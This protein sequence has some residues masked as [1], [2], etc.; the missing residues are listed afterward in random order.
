[1]LRK[2]GRQHGAPIYVE[3]R[4]MYL[5]LTAE[6]FNEL[7]GARYAGAPP[8][9]LA[10]DQAALWTG[11]R[12]GDI[13]VLATDHSWLLR[14]K[15]DSTNGRNGTVQAFLNKALPCHALVRRCREGRIS[16]SISSRRPQP[17]EAFWS[18]T[19]K[20]HSGHRSR[21]QLQWDPTEQRIIDATAMHTNADFSPY[22][23]WVVTWSRYTTTIGRGEI[24][25]QDAKVTALRGRGR[26]VQRK[27]FRL[28]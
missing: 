8:L 1:M 16:M 17:S 4:P 27:L 3:T 21:R 10:A 11:L 25:A 18:G 9:R 20:R 22:D 23:G 5:H 19:S 24:V 26:I 7:D 12:Y 13:D 2:A 6:R 28:L 15:L 14:D